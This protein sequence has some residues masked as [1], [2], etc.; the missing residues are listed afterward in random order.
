M[1]PIKCVIVV[2]SRSMRDAVRR[3]FTIL[4]FLIWALTLKLHV[5]MLFCMSVKHSK[6]LILPPRVPLCQFLK[7]KK[8]KEEEEEEEETGWCRIKRKL[9]YN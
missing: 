8:K 3:E 5:K 1:I 6:S 9:S 4:H 2:I 7:K